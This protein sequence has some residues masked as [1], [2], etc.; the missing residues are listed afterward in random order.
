MPKLHNA[1][2]PMVYHA[3][4]KL[5]KSKGVSILIFSNLPLVVLDTLADQDRRYLFLK[6]KLAGGVACAWRRS[7][8]GKA[9]S[10]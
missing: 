8:V 1:D 2:F 9:S 3:S 4:N 6:G 7:E 10:V 5:S